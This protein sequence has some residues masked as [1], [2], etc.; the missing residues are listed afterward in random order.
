MLFACQCHGDKPRRIGLCGKFLLLPSTR[1]NW[2]RKRLLADQKL[3]W[4]SRIRRDWRRDER[5]ARG[6]VS[7]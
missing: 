5:W 1:F 4:S 6:E 7:R 2:G 3:R